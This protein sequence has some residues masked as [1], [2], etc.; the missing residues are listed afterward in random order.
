MFCRPIILCLLKRI[1]ET[2]LVTKGHM[3]ASPALN[4]QIPLHRLYT[5]CCKVKL[6]NREMSTYTQS[7][8]IA[9][10]TES[11]TLFTN[12]PPVQQ[13]LY[14]VLCVHLPCIPTA[15]L[16]SNTVFSPSRIREPINVSPHILANALFLIFLQVIN[17]GQA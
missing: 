16:Q 3:L 13:N 5:D 17:F 15:A 9:H 11:M 7:L 1:I 6:G 2:I 10:I 4:H 12:S 8:Y 14:P